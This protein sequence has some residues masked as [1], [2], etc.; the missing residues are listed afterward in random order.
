MVKTELLGGQEDRGLFAATSR[1]SWR[2]A[3]HIGIL[4]TLAQRMVDQHQRQHRLGDRRGADADAGVV[5][6]FGG[7][8]D[9]IPRLVDG[10]TRNPD[11]GS[12]LDGD[13]GNDIL[14]GGNAAKNAG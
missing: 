10:V 1:N 9:R 2:R 7:Y 13:V 6:T 11:A 12:R 4:G 3:H 5:A 14:A 8:P